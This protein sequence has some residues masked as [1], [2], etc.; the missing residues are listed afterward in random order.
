MNDQTDG[1]LNAAHR[2]L[3]NEDDENG[4]ASENK[5]AFSRFLSAFNPRKNDD[6]EQ[7]VLDHPTMRGQVVGM[8]NLRRLSLEDVAI[9]KVEI[10]AV[11]HDIKKSKLVS[12]FRESGLTRLP[13]FEGTLDTPLGFIHLKDFALKHGFGTAG[14]FSMKDLVRPLIFAPPSMGIGVL[15]QKMQNERIHMALVI[16]EYGGVD[17]LVTIEDL[18]EQVIGQIDDEHDPEDASAWT[19]EAP[20][21]YLADARS[22]LTEFEAEIGLNLI[23]DLEDDEVDTLGGIIFVLTGRIPTR[24]EVI[25]HPLGVE[26][27]IVDA[28]A[29]RIKRLRVRLPSAK[30]D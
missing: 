22:D 21:I 11:P 27:E 20:G 8:V 2:A 4:G 12:V 15:L 7:D 25:P 26:F 29:R 19:Q 30:D 10:V 23:K 16:D 3:E 18:I 28:D 13:V 24:G 17:G 5:G 9:P 1:S 6:L 14:A